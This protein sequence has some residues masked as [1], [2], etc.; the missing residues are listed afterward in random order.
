MQNITLLLTALQARHQIQSATQGHA[1]MTSSYGLPCN[2][3]VTSIPGD[4]QSRHQ[5]RKSPHPGQLYA[6]L[7]MAGDCVRPARAVGEGRASICSAYAVEAVGLRQ[8]TK[9]CAGVGHALHSGLT[10]K[11]CSRKNQRLMASKPIRQVELL[12]D[13]SDNENPSLRD[14]TKTRRK[15]L[16]WKRLYS[17]WSPQPHIGLS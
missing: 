13:L 17:P 4:L 15:R 5:R 11:N 10:N 2:Y 9:E 3:K 7:S 12:I 1:Q 8:P 14:D 6:Y 16:Q